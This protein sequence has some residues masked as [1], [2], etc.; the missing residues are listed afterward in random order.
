[1]SPK[2]QATVMRT[3]M[4]NGFAPA[5]YRIYSGTYSY[6]VKANI[7]ETNDWPELDAFVQEHPDVVIAMRRKHWEEWP[8]KPEGMEIVHHQILVDPKPS[9]EYLL[10]IRRTTPELAA[11]PDPAAQ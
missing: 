11:P 8:N 7:F 5:S 6:Y 10:A 9:N 3:Y 1:M 2:A 4:L